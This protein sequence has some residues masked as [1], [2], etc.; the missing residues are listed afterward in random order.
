M[1]FVQELH[2]DLKDR[3]AP[4]A[5]ASM[6]GPTVERDVWWLPPM[7]HPNSKLRRC[8]DA[9]TGLVSLAVCSQL[10]LHMLWDFFPKSTRESTFRSSAPG[11]FLTLCNA[12]VEVWFAVDILLNC[13]TGFVTA[14]KKLVMDRWRV[15]SNY[16]FGWFLFDLFAAF[17]FDLFY[18]ETHEDYNYRCAKNS[19]T[20]D[21]FYCRAKRRSLVVR[22]RKVG[23]ALLR[24]RVPRLARRARQAGLLKDVMGW[25]PS[26]VRI[27]RFTRSLRFVKWFKFAKLFAAPR[28]FRSI[29][30]LDSPPSK[31][32]HPGAAAVGAPSNKAWRY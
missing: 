26:V 8:W 11:A 27:V 13:C 24:L 10:L 17:P 29:Q 23:A 15:L 12:M 16:L 20:T 7:V 1:S 9:V 28:V 18:F 5:L 25:V 30:R 2:H 21:L 32:D 3:R 6:F 22:V 4:S 31:D 19:Q 14:D